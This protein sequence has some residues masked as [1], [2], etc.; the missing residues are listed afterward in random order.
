MSDLELPPMPD[1]DAHANMPFPSTA[2]QQALKAW[3]S[4]CA[5]VIEHRERMKETTT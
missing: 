5:R 3:E 4:V 1:A 2:Y